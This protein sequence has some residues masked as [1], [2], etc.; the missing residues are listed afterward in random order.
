MKRLI[1]IC[2]ALV[3][4]I[5]IAIP[6]TTLAQDIRTPRP[7][8]HFDLT[9]T[10]QSIDQPS[11]SMA[12]WPQANPA[13]AN[14]W[15]I[16]DLVNGSPTIIGWVVD[17]RTIYGTV[18]GDANGQFTFTYGGVLDT[19]QSGSIHGIV[20]ITTGQGMVYL[21][22]QG[23]SET[24]IKETYT[25]G[26]VSAWCPQGGFPSVGA[27]FAQFYGDSNLAP[28]PDEY[29]A[30]MYGTVLPL[31]PKT[32][33]ASFSGT[34]TVESGTGNY[35]AI[36]GTARFNPADSKPIIL[37]VYP[38]QHVYNISGAIV[39]RGFSSIERARLPQVEA[40]KV[41]DA[42]QKWLKDRRR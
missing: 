25:F 19:I 20:V 26:E 3:M 1:F 7:P 14:S 21:L 13:G 37:S 23:T 39:I 33:G 30:A 2:L 18:S 5:A 6:A 36:H 15:P 8:R 27:F 12:P 35:A 32:L 22:A 4:I 38:N 11:I 34:V 31:L 24:T 16:Y 29:L 9:M 17:S 42:I 41:K 40:G 28:I 10:P